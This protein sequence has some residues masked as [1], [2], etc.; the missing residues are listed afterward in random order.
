VELPVERGIPQ[1]QLDLAGQQ[2][3][4]PE[5]VADHL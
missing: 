4:H 5:K 1:A 3:D 2:Y